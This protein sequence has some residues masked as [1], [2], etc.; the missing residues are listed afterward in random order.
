MALRFLC[1]GQS[2]NHSIERGVSFIVESQNEDGSWGSPGTVYESALALNGL[3]ACKT[4]LIEYKKGVHYL[5]KEQNGNGSWSDDSV[6]WEYYFKPDEK[7]RAY[8]ANHVVVTALS[9]R[10]L[11][12]HKMKCDQTKPIR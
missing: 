9:V 5:L 6:I 3:A 12:N 10:A 2:L 4:G 8:D 1:L 11:N 7:W